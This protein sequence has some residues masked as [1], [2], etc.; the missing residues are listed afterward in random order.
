MDTLVLGN[1]IVHRRTQ[2]K[3]AKRTAGR[4]GIVGEFFSFLWDQKLWWMILMMTVFLISGCCSYSPRD[5]QSHRS[6]THS[7]EPAGDPFTGF[8]GAGVP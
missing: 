8:P 2:K 1:H 5:R 7:S 6:S 4:F 3:S